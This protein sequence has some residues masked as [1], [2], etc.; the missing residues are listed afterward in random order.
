MD[1]TTLNKQFAGYTGT[2]PRYMDFDK[3]SGKPLMMTEQANIYPTPYA[4][5]PMGTNDGTQVRLYS[6]SFNFKIVFILKPFFKKINYFQC[7]SLT[8]TSDEVES[9]QNFLKF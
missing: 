9:A 5:M 4:T 6:N 8:K 7:H 2:A 3:T 1:S